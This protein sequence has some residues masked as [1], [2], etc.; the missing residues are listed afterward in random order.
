M[1]VR[2]FAAG[3]GAAFFGVVVAVL[4]VIFSLVV[5]MMNS[6]APDKLEPGPHFCCR[7][8]LRALHQLR[9]SAAA[10]FA[11]DVAFIASAAAVPSA[12]AAAEQSAAPSAI[13]PAAS[14]N[15]AWLRDFVAGRTATLARIP[16]RQTETLRATPSPT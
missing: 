9:R 7:R 16:L 14:A 2:C 1:P 3:L 11:T 12:A 5:G 10:S 15:S 8:R 6:T 13:A 4:F